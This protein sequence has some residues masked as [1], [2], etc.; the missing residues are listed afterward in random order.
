MA[1]GLDVQKLADSI[2]LKLIRHADKKT[3]VSLDEQFEQA[4]ALPQSTEAPKA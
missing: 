2:S 3:D 4:P 1:G